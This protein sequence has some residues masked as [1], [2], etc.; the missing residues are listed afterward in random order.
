MQTWAVQDA[1]ARFSEFLDACLAQGPQV[2]TRRGAETA[3]LVPVEVWRRLQAVAKPSL[4]DL[5][6]SDAGRGELVL[7]ERGQ[8]RRKR[9]QEVL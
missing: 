6:L 3:V 4:K 1:K 9:V 5:L 8:A 7:P 2:V